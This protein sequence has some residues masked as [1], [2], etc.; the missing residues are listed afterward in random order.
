MKDTTQEQVRSAVARVTTT[1]ADGFITMDDAYS[2]IADERAADY[3]FSIAQDTQQHLGDWA[4]NVRDCDKFARFVM[5]IGMLTHIKQ[6]TRMT[7]LG[8]GLW[9][10]VKDG[11]GGHAI[12]F[13]VT[14]K[15][16]AKE[17]TVRFFEPQTGQEVFLSPS[18]RI[19]TL[20]II[21]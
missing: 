16:G 10:Y 6:V 17:V 3:F 13:L 7:G 5:F 2:A 12:N 20:W 1:I 8:L 21:I 14:K 18:E 15:L 4:K 19:N 11:E 9:A